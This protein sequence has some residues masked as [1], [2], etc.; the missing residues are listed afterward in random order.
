MGLIRPA[1]TVRRLCYFD[2]QQVASARSLSEL[3]RQGAGPAQIRRSLEVLRSWLPGAAEAPLDQL[4]V[5]ERGDGEL[6]VRLFD[7]QLAEPCGQLRFAFGGEPGMR[8]VAAVLRPPSRRSQEEWFAEGVRLEET[9]D[10]ERAADAYHECLLA[11]AP[12]AEV[13]F[14]LGNVLHA[15][16]RKGEAAQRF[17]Q[18]VEIEPEYVEAWNNLGNALAELGRGTRA[19]QAYQRALDIE[20]AYADAHFNLAA[21]LESLDRFDDAREH[22][23]AYLRQDPGSPDA[24]FVRERLAMSEAGRPS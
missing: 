2:F 11:G 20:P 23:L 22:W 14:N 1:K 10:L 19:V 21:T 15:L 9:G 16:R 8:P 6:L 18:A 5:L 7:G 12:R 4:R 13:C 3:L 17:M 24:E